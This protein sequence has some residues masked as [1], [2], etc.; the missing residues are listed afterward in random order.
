MLLKCYA[1][2]ISRR[3][4]ARKVYVYG[5]EAPLLLTGDAEGE[6]SA[7]VMLFRNGIQPRR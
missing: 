2:A 5:K 1:H 7:S 4:K 3:G 6:P